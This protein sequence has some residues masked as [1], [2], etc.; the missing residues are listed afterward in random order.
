MGTIMKA[1]CVYCGFE[2]ELF[3]GGGKMDCNIETI[4]DALSEREQQE[5]SKAIQLGATRISIDRMP[6]ACVSCGAIHAVPVV[7]YTMNGEKKKLCGACPTCGKTEY[8][9]LSL[10]PECKKEL[11][12]SETGLWD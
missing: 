2:K 3:I 8:T 4:M 9:T 10:C 6:C 5:L 11:A 7:S 1:K 12:V